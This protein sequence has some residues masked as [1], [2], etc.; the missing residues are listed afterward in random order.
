MISIRCNIICVAR[1]SSRLSCVTE[2]PEVKPASNETETIP[3]TL[4]PT[5]VSISENARLVARELRQVFRF[6]FISLV[7]SNRHLS[8]NHSVLRQVSTCL[9]TFPKLETTQQ[10]IGSA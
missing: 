4:E 2:S 1:K 10:G 6:I 8:K 9:A 7:S 3:T 5:N